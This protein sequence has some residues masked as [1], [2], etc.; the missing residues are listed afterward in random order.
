MDLFAKI[1]TSNE[2]LATAGREGLVITSRHKTPITDDVLVKAFHPTTGASRSFLLT[3]TEVEE[4]HGALGKWLRTG[5]AGLVNGAPGPGQGS[6]GSP[7]TMTDARPV[8]DRIAARLAE[9]AER[10]KCDEERHA[11]TYAGFSRDELI[12][13]LRLMK[14]NVDIAQTREGEWRSAMEYDR[15][16][17]AAAIGRLRTALAGRKTASAADLQAA[18]TGEDRAA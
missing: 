18:L 3:R 13:E 14:L 15:A 11:G 8:L 9:D 6:S 17:Y 10:R 5:W 4:L 7:S 2:H 16:R 12:A 1:H